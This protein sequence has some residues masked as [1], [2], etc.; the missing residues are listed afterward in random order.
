MDGDETAAPGALDNEIV[1][2]PAR[3]ELAT[4][5]PDIDTR[6]C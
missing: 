4:P 2:L 5:T 6:P 1:T 3:H